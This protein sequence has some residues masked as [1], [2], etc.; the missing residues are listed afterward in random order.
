MAD[1][2]EPNDPNEPTADQSDAT[3]ATVL[4]AQRDLTEADPLIIGLKQA[5]YQ[6]LWATSAAQTLQII[7]EHLPHLLILDNDI[8]GKDGLTVLRE[9]RSHKPSKDLPVI[10]SSKAYEPDIVSEAMELG[11]HDY[12]LKA[13]MD[14][15]SIIT[16]VGTY[17][18]H[19]HWV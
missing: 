9:V 3:L 13:D 8:H 1:P 17:V 18:Q 4:L 16:M 2:T 6:V 19:R 15:G 11:V 10:I 14:L 5:G 12:I 7:K